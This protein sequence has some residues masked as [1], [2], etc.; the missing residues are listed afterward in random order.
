MN[1]GEYK[2]KMEVINK[3]MQEISTLTEKMAFANC[4]N[5]SNPAFVEL[6]EKQDNLIKAA[7]R[8]ITEMLSQREN[9]N[10]L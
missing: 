3:R 2:A 1:Y 6:M 7:D 4:A 8:L 5:P 10:P 9:D